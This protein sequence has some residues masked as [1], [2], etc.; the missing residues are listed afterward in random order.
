M[1]TNKSILNGVLLVNKSAGMTSHDVVQRIRKLIG[2]RRVGHTGTLDPMATGLLA[3]C[4]GSATKIA[5][6]VSDMDKTYEADIRLGRTSKTYDAEGVDA[7]QPEQTVP[8][9]S[10][11]ELELLLS[12]FVGVIRQK[13]PVFSAVR[14]GGKRLYKLA[15]KGISTDIPEREIEIKRIEIMDFSPPHLRIQVSCTKGTYIRS[16]AHD[17][18]RRLE[19]GGYLADLERLN[20]GHLNVNDALT[21]EQIANHR[22]NGTLANHLLDY[23]DVLDY[24]A[25]LIRDE[26]RQFVESG[27]QPRNTDILGIEGAFRP[28]DR[29]LLK[30]DRGSVLAVGIA[31]VAS[32]SI[33]GSAQQN[34]LFNYVRVLN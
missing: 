3:V 33:S 29:I 34:S 28:G 24:G 22:D 17:I 16:L 9:V 6:F 20:I 21:L 14:I 26:F 19:C 18:G 30:D 31:G 2:Q 12:E 27:R 11:S 32:D 10:Q 25:I 8:H 1:V 4:L 5:R 7:N 15:R 13:V 23:D